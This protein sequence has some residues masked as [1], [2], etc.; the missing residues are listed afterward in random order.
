MCNLYSMTS[1][2]EAIR[3]FAK[4]MKI[5]SN[6]G[7]LAPTEGI[8]ANAWGPI[9]R[10]TP[11]GRELAT[12]RWGMPSNPENLGA[13]NY[14]SGVSNVRHHWIDWWQPWLG[15]ENRCVVPWTSFS[16]PDQA[17]KSNVLHWFALSEERPLAFFAGIWTPQHTSCRKVKD[18]VTCDDL[19]AFVTTKPNAEVKAVH[20]KAMPFI[21]RT[22]EEVDIW[23]TEPWDAVKKLIRPLPDG[24]LKI[25]GRGR[26]KDGPGMPFD[27]L[28]AE[29]PPQAEL[30]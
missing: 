11:D 5:A 4:F 15:V 23:L 13:K 12:C 8:F 29:L 18:G 16:E 24:T 22:E 26:K 1:N 9:V 30:F 14:D 25:V 10:N 17:T 2:Q 28:I 21:L 20:P 7:N 3:A 19:Y 6:A 27:S